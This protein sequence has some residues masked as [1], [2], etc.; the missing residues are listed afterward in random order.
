MLFVAL[1]TGWKWRQATTDCQSWRVRW[2]IAP[3]MPSNWQ[4]STSCEYYHQY[5]SLTK[6]ALTPWFEMFKLKNSQQRCTIK[7]FSLSFAY[8][9][10]CS[11]RIVKITKNAVFSIYACKARS[12]RCHLVKTPVQN[13]HAHDVPFFT[14]VFL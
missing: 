3:R 8:R 4:H 6:H 2:R 9:L 5:L 13:M 10:F 1:I 7:H 12:W 11:H 14:N